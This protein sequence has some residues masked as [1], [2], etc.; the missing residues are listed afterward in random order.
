MKKCFYLFFILFIFSFAQLHA[1]KTYAFIKYDSNYIHQATDSANLLAFYKKIDAL[2]NGTRNRVTIAHYGGSHIQAGQWSEML[3]DSFQAM[4]NFKGGG[5]FCF[6]FRTANTNGPPF[7]KSLS[8]GTW[9]RC[10]CVPSELCAPLGMAGIAAINNEADASFGMQLK[11]NGHINAFNSIKV[12]HNFNAS[13]TFEINAGYPVAYKRME[14]QE[15]GYTIF[16]FAVPVDSVT[17]RLHKLDNKQDDFILRGFSIEN[18][19]PGFYF[20]AMGVNGASTN[21][22]IHCSEFEKELRDV[23]P[24]L[25][26]FSI[27]VNDAQDP[28]FNAAAFIARYDSLVEMVK[29]VSPDCAILFTTIS[30]NYIK[31]KT[32]NTRSLATN[33]AL[34]TLTEKHNAAIWDM[35]SVMGGIRSISTWYT[36]GLAAADK[37]HFNTEGYHIIG[38]LMFEAIL[39]SYEANSITGK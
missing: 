13:F 4:G 35:F 30:D 26:I 1:Q 34:F 23:K 37:I 10:R 8:T 39:K 31:K 25:F 36:N 3:A 9:Q 33:A 16:T 27:G 12:F 7:Y 21:S 18:S 32:S 19:E 17:F 20:A 24:D 38:A 28:D 22:Y 2:K 29:H 11:P 6:P 15:Y 5:A 14:V